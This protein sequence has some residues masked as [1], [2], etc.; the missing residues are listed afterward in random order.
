MLNPR[1]H[2]DLFARVK[3]LRGD[4]LKRF[5]AFY[6]NELD[7]VEH[8]N[9]AAKNLSG[10]N[11][12]RLCVALSL[13]AAPSIAFFDEPSTGLDPMAK[14]S[15][16]RVLTQL[17]RSKRASI[18]L[19]THSLTEAENLAHKIGILVLSYYLNF[20]YKILNR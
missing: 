14:R 19:T 5:V 18:L 4:T 2:L 7:L 17:L 12:R 6:I 16:W 8:K 15:L 10:G 9:K 3:G 13:I 1:E 11:R 20:I